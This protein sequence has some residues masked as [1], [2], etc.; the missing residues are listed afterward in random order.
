MD[1]LRRQ[2]DEVQTVIPYQSITELHRILDPPK[3]ASLQ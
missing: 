2:V 3:S 1:P